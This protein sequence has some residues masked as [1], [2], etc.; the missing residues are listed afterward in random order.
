MEFSTINPQTKAQSCLDKWTVSRRAAGAN[1][2]G[3]I[4][5]DGDGANWT[6]WSLSHYLRPLRHCVKAVKRL[7]KWL[8]RLNLSRRNW[9]EGRRNRAKRRRQPPEARRR[10]KKGRRNRTEGRRRS[11]D[12]RRNPMAGRR[13]AGGRS[14]RAEKRRR[15]QV[16]STF[17]A[18]FSFEEAL[19]E[20]G[21]Q[22]FLLLSTPPLIQ[23]SLSAA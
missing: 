13:K 23:G 9:F 5:G 7:H 21:Q 22:L 8:R 12:R 4:T 14:S 20:V 18:F 17:H 2:L 15:R 3:K 16:V 1:D 10:S 6:G 19:G 11:P